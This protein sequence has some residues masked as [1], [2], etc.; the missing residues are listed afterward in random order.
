MKSDNRWLYIGGVALLVI[1]VVVGFTM[2][3]RNGD[4]ESSPDG[5]VGTDGDIGDAGGADGGES[6]G[7]GAAPEDDTDSGAAVEVGD[8]PSDPEACRAY[9]RD[10]AER[11]ALASG[12]DANGCI[13]SLCS[14]EGG[15]D[16][17]EGSEPSEPV[18]T[19]TEPEI[20]EMPD[21]CEA[22]CRLL[23]R[24]GELREGTSVEDC[25]SALCGSE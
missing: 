7:D 5:S 21:D 22:Q 3:D 10:L 20:P 19:I 4:D 25:I 9:C 6:E 13:S 11:G 15:G 16:E 17:E 24:R 1:I 2:R 18:P 8:V 23:Q 14:D 12:T